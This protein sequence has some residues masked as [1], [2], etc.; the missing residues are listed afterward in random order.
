MLGLQSRSIRFYN[1][2]IKNLSF[3]VVI[4]FTVFYITVVEDFFSFIYKLPKT[5]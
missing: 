1:C 3:I 2:D 4:R 5:K